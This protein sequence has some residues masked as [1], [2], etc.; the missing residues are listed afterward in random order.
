MAPLDEEANEIGVLFD[1]VDLPDNV[2]SGPEAV[3]DC[4]R[5]CGKT[6]SRATS[7]I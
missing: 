3:D 5:E 7:V 1:V 4:V 2:I 6:G